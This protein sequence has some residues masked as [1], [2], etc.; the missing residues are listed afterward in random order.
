MSRARAHQQRYCRLPRSR[1]GRRG[2]KRPLRRNRPAQPRIRNCRRPCR[3]CRVGASSK[4]TDQVG[5][6]AFATS[7]SS[8]SSA[9]G[10]SSAMSHRCVQRHGISRLPEIAG[11]K[12]QSNRSSATR[13]ATSISQGRAGH[14]RDRGLRLRH[15]ELQH[16]HLHGAAHAEPLTL[17]RPVRAQGDR[18]DPGQVRR[19][20]PNGDVDVSAPAARLRRAGPQADIGG[21]LADP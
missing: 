15:P 12:R 21:T 20:P 9:A 18:E 16:D 6:S 5:S 2:C 3:L 17:V 1:P 4:A 10:F 8:S 13:S 19:I 14:M 11:D 7:R